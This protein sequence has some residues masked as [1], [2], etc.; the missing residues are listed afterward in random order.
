M[1][2]EFKKR[3]VIPHGGERVVP[4]SSEFKL[5]INRNAALNPYELKLFNSE[6]EKFVD[7]LLPAFSSSSEI[8]HKTN[9]IIIKFTR[10]RR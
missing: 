6:V 3:L 8:D 10:R 1:S 5:T 9:Q 4:I 7:N 2:E